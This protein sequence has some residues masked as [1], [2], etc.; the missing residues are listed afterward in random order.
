MS[1]SYTVLIQ[2][3]ANLSAPDT[4]AKEA[5]E[6][7][8]Q[9]VL[10]QQ[11]VPDDSM[12]SI[13]IGTDSYLQ[14]LNNKYRQIDAPTDVLSFPAEPLPPEVASEEEGNYLGD[15]AISLPYATRRAQQEGHSTL[16][17]IRLLLIHGTLHLLGHDHNTPE[18]QKTMWA[19][20]TEALRALNMSL[21]IPD[22][23]HED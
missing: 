15:I 13:V 17:E 14:E 7:A 21:E 10:V 3:Y 5:L 18:S 20:Q 19:A 23:I 8:V 11:N 6:E 4:L 2:M 9:T 22:Y 12:L 16:D 1:E